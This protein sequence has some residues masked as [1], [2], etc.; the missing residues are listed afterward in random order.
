M[1]IASMNSRVFCKNLG[2]INREHR[3]YWLGK[4]DTL[5]GLSGGSG[6]GAGG[7][8]GAKG[9]GEATLLVATERDNKVYTS[10]S[11]C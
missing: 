11:V 3:N 6:G 10:R 1:H 5:S 4:E 2:E 8:T 7:G 9:I